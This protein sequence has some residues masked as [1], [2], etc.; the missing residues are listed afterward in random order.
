MQE[1][2]Q[3]VLIDPR[4]LSR[5]QVEAV[6]E[7]ACKSAAAI[8]VDKAAWRPDPSAKSAHEIVRHMVE[9]NRSIAKGLR[10]GQALD[11]VEKERL[12]VET[13]DFCGARGALKHSGQAL[14]AAYPEVPGEAVRDAL[15]QGQMLEGPVRLMAIGLFHLAYHWG[16]LAYLQTLWGDG[17]D[18]FLQ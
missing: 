14:A 4:R 2:K 7:L 12:V 13:A 5:L 6:T 1:Q 18:H 16:Q 10:S 17:E 9:V 15:A 11:A 3:S 8:P